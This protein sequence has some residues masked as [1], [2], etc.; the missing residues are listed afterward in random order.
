MHTLN[1]KALRQ[2]LTDH[3]TGYNQGIFVTID[4]QYAQNS[5]QPGMVAN[6]SKGSCHVQVDIPR[7]DERRL[8]AFTNK[9]INDLCNRTNRFCFGRSYL[10][11]ENRLRNI[12]AIEIGR[13]RQRLHAHCI[14]LHQGNSGR[15]LDEISEFV[16]SNCNRIFKI[17]GSNA[18][19]VE[20]F[21]S[22][23]FWETYFT[24]ETKKMFN[25]Y[26]GFMNIDLH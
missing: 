18:Y 10:R 7:I 1:I 23:R 4:T 19:K 21:D 20:A 15:S 11:N 26:N 22:E 13:D 25:L 9:N 12:S 14:M 24:K 6:H 17:S 16:I 3:I 5:V 2:Q 8:Y